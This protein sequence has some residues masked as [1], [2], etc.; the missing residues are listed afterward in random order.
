MYDCDLDSM[1]VQELKELRD[2]IDNA[3][4]AEIAKDRVQRESRKLP[5]EAAPPPAIDL[6]RERDAWAARRK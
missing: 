1:T 3:I 5:A 4:R 6:E 2:R